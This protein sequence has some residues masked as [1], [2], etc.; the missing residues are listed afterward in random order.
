[1]VR[2]LTM[3]GADVAIP[4]QGKFPGSAGEESIHP[5]A[6]CLL[7]ALSDKEKRLST[8]HLEII[9]HL[10]HCGAKTQI[11]DHVIFDLAL[12]SA[13]GRDSFAFQILELVIK[14]GAVFDLSKKENSKEGNLLQGLV[15]GKALEETKLLRGSI[16]KKVLLLIFTKNFSR[17]RI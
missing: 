15:Q 12:R 11:P 8:D 17:P 2:L 3:A 14:E 16:T 5:I 4:A 1:M 10:I 6:S 9:R 13:K 7:S